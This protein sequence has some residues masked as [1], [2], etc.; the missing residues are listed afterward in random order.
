MSTNVFIYIRVCMHV[1]IYIHLH[2]CMERERLGYGLACGL[3]YRMFQVLI[4]R[5]CVLCLWGEA[6]CKC[7]LG[8]VSLQYLTLLLVDFSSG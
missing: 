7:L 3:S 4:R 5:M 8:P 1:H 6:C 2:I